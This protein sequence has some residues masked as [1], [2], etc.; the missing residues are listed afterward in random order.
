[1]RH[2]KLISPA[3]SP[4]GMRHL[5]TVDAFQADCLI[6]ALLRFKAHYDPLSVDFRK[7]TNS[8]VHASYE[9]FRIDR[10]KTIIGWISES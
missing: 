2:F 6:D 10:P 1:M 9:V 5:K 3:V 8:H 7:S 4:T